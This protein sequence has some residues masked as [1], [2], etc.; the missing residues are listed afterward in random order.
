MLSNGR[1]IRGGL[2]GSFSTTIIQN[3]IING[4]SVI[5]FTKPSNEYKS[6]T[7]FQNPIELT[8]GVE[9]TF[10]SSSSNVDVFAI[11]VEIDL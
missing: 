9:L 2:S 1:I 10:H 3:I 6:I 4:S 11:W 5:S 7:I 8:N